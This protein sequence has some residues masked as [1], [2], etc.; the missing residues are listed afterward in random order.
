MLTLYLIATCLEQRILNKVSKFLA[1]NLPYAY[2]QVCA[3]AQTRATC[4]IAYKT[5]I[6]Q[7]LIA[8]TTL[9]IRISMR[10]IISRP[11][12]RTQTV[13][14]LRL[15]RE[16]QSLKAVYEHKTWLHISGQSCAFIRIR[17]C[18]ITLA[19]AADAFE[20]KSGRALS[21]CARLI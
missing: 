13:T 11:V 1:L 6:W 4:W 10:T 5:N 2:L 20:V 17:F 9:A 12:I 21:N 14:S 16:T 7:T 18:G 19:S 15:T 8:H 3:R